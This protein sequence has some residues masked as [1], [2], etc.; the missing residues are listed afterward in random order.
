MKN[1]PRVF[2]LPLSLTLLAVSAHVMHAQAIT[3]QITL[4]SSMSWCSDSMINGLFTQINTFRAQNNVPQL[5]MSTLGMKDAEIRAT[6]FAV[7]M[8]TTPPGTPGFYP[9]QGWDTTAASLG[10]NIVSENLAYITTDPVYIVTGVWQD[11]LHLA[12]MLNTSANVMGVSCVYDNGTAYWT[13]EPGI[14]S[15]GCSSSSNPTPGGVPTLDSEEW[16]FLTLINNYRAQNGLGPL[17]V[18]VM[19]ENASQWMSNDMATNNYASHT[20]SL[21][22]DP[23]T[24]LAAFGYTYTPWGENIAGGFSDAQDTFNQWQGACDPDQT[25][26]CTYAHRKTM[27]GPFTAIGI[28]HSYSGTSTYGWYWVTDFGGVLDQAISPTGSTGQV[29]VITSFTAAP[30]TIAPGQTATLSWNATGAT[31]LSINNGVGTVSTLTSTTVSPVQTTVYTLTASNATGSTTASV[32]VTVTATKDTQPPSTPT[33]SSAVAKSANEVDLAWTASTDNVGVAGYQILRNGSSLTSVSGTTR[34]YADTS[35]GAGVT[36]AY[37]VKAFDAAGNYSTASNSITVT[38]PAALPP[39]S[40][41]P[42]PATGAFTGCYYPDIDLS[43]TPTLIRTDSQVNF[44]WGASSPDPSLPAG[45]FSVRWQGNFTFTAGT[46]TFSALTSDGMRVYLDSDVLIDRWHDQQTALYRVQQ[47]VTAGV[48]LVT[49]EYYEHTGWSAANVT[50]QNITPATQPPTIQSFA[51][52]PSSV[53][54]GQPSTLAWTVAGATSITIDQGIG[55]V[56]SATSISVSP[57]Q[58]TTYTLTASNSAGS[59]SAKATVTVST[60]K[61]TQPP[62]MPV[63]VSV[64]A[65]SSNQVSL[66]WGASTDNVGVT[67]YQILRNGTA[68]GTVAGNVLSYSDSGVSPSSIY[69]YA[70]KAYDGAGNYSAASNA[71]SVSTPAAPVSTGSCAPPATESF[72]GCYYNNS[73]LSGTAALVRTDSSINFDWGT[74]SPSPALT[75]GQFSV[76][77]QG[78]FNLQGNYMFSVIAPSGIR[79]YID[80]ALVIDHWSSGVLFMYAVYPTLSQG[81]HLITLE[82]AESAN[83]SGVHLSWSQF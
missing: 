56:S 55:D 60:V 70:V 4:P 36:Y 63:L 45:N 61:D 26:A 51:A 37:S 24:R 34:S 17:Q 19:L 69:S 15:S 71:I 9:H 73:T 2:A 12:A 47:T 16:N 68:V 27:L 39:P 38:T 13:Y 76:R 59:V 43:G 72:T 66:T 62:S 65:I 7:Y 35:A 83:S 25:G 67:G 30:V 58:T 32:T 21:G 54:A 10:Y 78:Y 31:A 77:W 64:V 79:L 57:A 52:T 49:V 42:G 41:C 81:S 80:G 6:Q 3:H 22:R 50:W 40:S 5:G 23:G 48:H 44:D 29:P 18:S 75:P 20:D 46:Y 14:C 1:F 33:L 8:E 11:S 28:A 53:N 82:Y 74:G